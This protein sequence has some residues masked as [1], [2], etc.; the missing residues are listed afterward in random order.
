MVISVFIAMIF[1]SFT[2][3]ENYWK[4]FFSEFFK[5]KKLNIILIVAWYLICTT[6]NCDKKMKSLG[7]VILGNK[8]VFDCL[9]LPGT[10]W[11]VVIEP[12]YH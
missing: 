8:Q 2:L 1:L 4:H 11:E 12:K 9:C 5:I 10:E 3:N 7:L 6:I